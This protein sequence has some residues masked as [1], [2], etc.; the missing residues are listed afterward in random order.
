MLLFLQMEGF[1]PPCSSS[2][3]RLLTIPGRKNPQPSLLHRNS[4]PSFVYP[5]FWIF[6][7]LLHFG[8]EIVLF[9]SRK[10]QISYINCIWI[11]SSWSNH[12][13]FPNL[14]LS[15]SAAENLIKVF[16]QKSCCNP[17]I[18]LWQIMAP[19]DCIRQGRSIYFFGMKCYLLAFLLWTQQD[20]SALLTSKNYSSTERSWWK[21]ETS[22]VSYC[23]IF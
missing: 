5:F 2:W 3:H 18:F 20:F 17:F 8:K 12:K 15:S 14:I 21:R 9:P 23:F 22:P 7:F 4:Q 6:V 11:F 19:R 16:M 1:F 13:V 10:G